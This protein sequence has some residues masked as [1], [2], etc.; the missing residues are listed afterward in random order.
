M[1]RVKRVPKV[2]DQFPRVNRSIDHWARIICRD[3]LRARERALK[4]CF[5]FGVAAPHDVPAARLQFRE[6]CC[7]QNLVTGPVLANHQDVLADQVLWLPLGTQTSAVVRSVIPVALSF[8]LFV[9][10]QIVV[11][12]S[13]FF[14]MELIKE[15]FSILN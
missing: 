11:K 1:E 7:G 12:C 5:E 6:A 13:L 9:C 15:A 4:E 2:L 10:A 3:E 8:V 14:R